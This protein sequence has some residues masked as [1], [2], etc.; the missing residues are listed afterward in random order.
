MPNELPNLA[1]V[2]WVKRQQWVTV[3]LSWYIDVSPTDGLGM[4]R[5]YLTETLRPRGFLPQPVV[6]PRLSGSMLTVVQPHNI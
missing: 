3:G 2:L 4:N 6:E 5:N 1:G